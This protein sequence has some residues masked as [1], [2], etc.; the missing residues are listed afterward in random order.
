M[1]IDL[2]DE[3]RL[4]R[5]TCRDFAARELTP[6]A[7][8]WDREH[9]FPAHAIK[10]MAELGL[11]GVAV[12]T[13]WG[14]AGMDNVSY[15][16]AMEEISRGCASC[17]VAMSVNNSLYADPVMKYGTDQQKERWLTPFASG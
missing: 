7:K 9:H 5:D 4:L 16:L 17:G 3:Q 2:N 15:A 10:K 11:M 14:G 13:D 1:D 8:K 6:N 12:P